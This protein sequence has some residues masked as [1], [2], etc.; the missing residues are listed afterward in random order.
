MSVVLTS[1]ESAYSLRLGLSHHSHL[2]NHLLRSPSPKVDTISTISTQHQPVQD[3]DPPLRFSIV[4]I[5]RPEFGR[6]AILS[7]KSHISPTKCKSPSNP[8]DLSHS[9][10][11]ILALSSSYAVHRD[12]EY[13]G[14]SSPI[15][16]HSGLSRSGSLESLASNRSSLTGSL[17]GTPSLSSAAS[18]AAESVS[19]DSLPSSTSSNPSLWPA[20]VYCTRYSDR[21]SSGPR[22]RR[23]KRADS[24]KPT[25]ED[26]RPR[27]AFSAEQ[28][29]RLKTE[30]N[31]NRY[32]TEPRRQQL[33]RELGLNEAQIKIWFQNKRAK[34][35]KSS[36]K[37]NPL[38]LQ[39][40]A[41]GLY[42]HSTVPVDDDGEE[43]LPN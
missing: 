2:H 14:D 38:A 1:M 33:S 41:Q 32:L 37:K 19:G 29:A 11:K 15:Q 43:I 26:K 16:R 12:R 4:N 3:N 7:T 28:L 35:K 13:F 34:I 39:L 10:A 5:L 30:F 8:K 20:W 40:M 27:T 24:D 18:T 21:P 23:V 22:T 6:S 31:E 36:G 25:P 42:N 9:T 17:T